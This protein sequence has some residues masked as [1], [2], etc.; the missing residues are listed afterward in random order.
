MGKKTKVE[1]EQIKRDILFT[2]C[3]TKEHLHRWIK[4]FLE[5][6]LPNCI[7]SDND[8]LNPSNSNPTDLI[9]EMYSKMMDRYR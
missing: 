7:V 2:P 3:N 5:M 8:D 1:L 4:I 6:D 9:W